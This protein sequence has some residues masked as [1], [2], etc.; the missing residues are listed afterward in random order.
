MVLAD[1]ELP[2]DGLYR[3]LR[4]LE[5]DLA[6]RRVGDCLA[7]RRVLHAVLE[8]GRAGREV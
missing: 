5:Q 8:G 7:P 3:E 2:E 1:H 4:V 6:V